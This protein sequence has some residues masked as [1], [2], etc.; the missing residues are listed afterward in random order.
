MVNLHA[1]SAVPLHLPNLSPPENLPR[2]RVFH[3]DAEPAVNGH[4]AE[5]P[6]LGRSA[7]GTPAFEMKF[8]IDEAQ[9]REVE[10]SLRGTLELDPHADPGLGNGYRITSLYCDTPRFDVFRRVGRYGRFKLRLRQ[11]GEG[12]KLFLER[13][14][15]RGNR[16]RK[17]RSA[18]GLDELSRFHAAGMDP[19]W[20][21]TWFRRQLLRNELSPVCL[22]SYERV[23]YFGSGLEGPLRLT[24][25]REI[26]GELTSHWSLQGQERAKQVLADRVVCEFKFRGSL[27]TPFKSVISTLQLTPVGV[28]KF[29]H[30]L[31][32]AGIGVNGAAPHA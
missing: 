32:A 15:R 25:D 24:F 23:A 8:L 31:A 30:C 11:Y 10:A 28:S 6:S 13:K 4:S 1:E 27:P 2:L 14:A 16:V 20:E 9:A 21:G 19:H 26:R 18:I 5:S 29:R 7:D 22:I 3:A 12:E 17:R